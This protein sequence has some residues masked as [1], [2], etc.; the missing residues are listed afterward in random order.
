MESSGFRLFSRKTN[1]LG[2][3]KEDLESLKFSADYLLS[4]V[5]DVLY[6]NKLED[7]EKKELDNKPFE[8]RKLIMKIVNSFEFMRAKNANNFNISVEQNVPKYL[9]G[10]YTKLS[11]I[12]INLIS[13][14][15]KFTE[16]GTIK[17][18]VK[19]SFCEKGSA[20]VHFC[21]AD[22]GIG[23]SAEKQS[24][25]FNEFT[26]DSNS[27][28]FAGTGLG[29]AIVKRLLD[30]HNSTISLKSK[31]NEGTEFGF[32]I[33]YGI[34]QESEFTIVEEKKKV[35][36]SLDGSH[37]LIVDDNKINRLVTRKVL[38]LNNY[39]C[40]EAENGE[41]AVKRAK[42]EVF[43]LLLMDLNMPVMGGCEAVKLIREFD[44]Q[45]P[46]IALTAQDPSQLDEDLFQIGFNDIIIKPYANNEFLD[47]VKNNFLSTIKL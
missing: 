40:A 14:A 17:V 41:L 5:N 38:E 15:C 6:L 22:D 34:A 21:V 24:I 13:N 32:T 30:L 47:K 1:N 33:T 45:T 44:L 2:D 10:D 11:Q 36:K 3:Y 28:N 26:Q 35:D 25:I 8:I 20:S 37:I 18:T 19:A 29:L 9:K 12:L 23:I 16:E 43:D 46:I 42:E 31:R 7:F 39:T 27:T 4:M